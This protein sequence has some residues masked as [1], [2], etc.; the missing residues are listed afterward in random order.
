MLGGDLHFGIE[1]EIT[2]VKQLPYIIL[3]SSHIPFCNK[4]DVAPYIIR[5][6]LAFRIFLLLVHSINTKHNP[7]N[8]VVVL[9][10]LTV[11]RYLTSSRCV[12]EIVMFINYCFFFLYISFS[13][14]FVNS[15]KDQ[16]TNK[17]VVVLKQL[18]ASAISNSPPPRVVYWGLLRLFLTSEPE[19]GTPVQYKFR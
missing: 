8:H 4:H 2:Q 1:T 10:H 16:K 7:S 6:P 9:K 5:L 11:I 18:V 14:R 19:L 12:L 3:T 15:Q 13:V 17:D